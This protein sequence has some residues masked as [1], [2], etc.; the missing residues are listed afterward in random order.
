M[1]RDL[2]ARP[3]GH[4]DVHQ[5]DVG[6]LAVD[7]LDSLITVADRNHIDVFIGERELDDPL[8]RDAVVGEQELVWH[9]V[10]IG[11]SGA[12]G[13]RR[14]GFGPASS[15]ACDRACTRMKSTISCI[16]VPG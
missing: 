4:R 13:Y 11:A 10:V 16:E 3:P 12:E 5:H 6:R 15:G 7:G 14:Q 2:V 1:L 8:N 9:L